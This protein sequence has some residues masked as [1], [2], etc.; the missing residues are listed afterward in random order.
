MEI[1]IQNAFVRTDENGYYKILG[2]TEGRDIITV[3]S[4]LVADD[5][6]FICKSIYIDI[7]E[8]KIIKKDFVLTLSHIN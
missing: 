8:N 2:L 1:D 6:S 3:N 7:I 5:D 4:S